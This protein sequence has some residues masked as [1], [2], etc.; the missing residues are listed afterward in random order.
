M[1]AL[2]Y[3]Y[4]LAL[5]VWLGGMAVLGVLVAPTTFEV[6]QAADPAAG[7]ELAGALFGMTL[8][9]FQYVAY[10]CGATLL[11]SIVVMALLGPRPSSFGVRTAIIAMMLAVAVYSGMWVLRDIQHLQAAAGTLPSQLP[12]T[13][14][15][16]IRFDQLHVLSTRLMGVN[17]IGALVLLYWEAR[18]HAG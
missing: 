6:L 1:L 14:A 8:A 16:R 5:V 15:R 4:V 17:M 10:A 13:D 7:R 12:A 11:V 3:A 18:E 2:R 9:R